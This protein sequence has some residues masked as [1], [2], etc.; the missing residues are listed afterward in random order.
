[1]TL[2]RLERLDAHQAYEEACRRRAWAR[3]RACLLPWWAWWRRLQLHC[4]IEEA[5]EEADFHASRLTRDDLQRE[6]IS[7]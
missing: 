2:S 7:T 4:L 5:G 3:A 6:G 1:M